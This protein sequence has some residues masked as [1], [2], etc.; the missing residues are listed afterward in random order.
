M[1]NYLPLVVTVI[2]A[3][4]ANTGKWDLF[5]QQKCLI[6]ARKTHKQPVELDLDFSRGSFDILQNLFYPYPSSSNQT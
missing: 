1:F 3:A 4:D 5:S 6:I 2:G